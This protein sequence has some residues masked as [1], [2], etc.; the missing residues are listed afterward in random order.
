[1]KNAF[2]KNGDCLADGKVSSVI[3]KIQIL[4]R[5]WLVFS[6][7]DEQM[8]QMDHSFLANE[9]VGRLMRE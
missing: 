2:V 7:G 1:M 5:Y 3:E 8:E 4:W 9:K 6:G